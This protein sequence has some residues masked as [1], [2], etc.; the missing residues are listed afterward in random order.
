MWLGDDYGLSWD[1]T[2]NAEVGEDALRAYAGAP[3]YF[4][5]SNLEEHGPAYFMLFSATSRLIHAAAPGWPVADGRHLTNY[6]TFLA[7]VVIFYQ[8][9]LRLVSPRT[10]WVGAA[11]FATQPLLFGNAFVNQK[12]IPFMVFFMATVA[13]GI[14][15]VEEWNGSGL[16]QT[17]AHPQ[18]GASAW[19]DLVSGLRLEWRAKS[20]FARFLW[21]AALS[22]A[23]LLAL[24][25]LFVGTLARLG[26]A[27][28][29][30]AHEGRAPALIQQAFARV[31]SDA[32][33]T[34]VDAYLAKF[35]TLY[36]NLRVV[37]ASALTLGGLVALARAFPS[38]GQALGV[39]RPPLRRPGWLAS[40]VLLGLTI[41]IRQVGAFAGGMVSLYLLYRA[42]ARASFS[43]LAYWVIA[44][45]VTVASWP[46]LW[47]DPAGRLSGSLLHAA[48]FPFHYTL[49]RGGQIPSDALPPDYFPTLAGI[50][51]TEPAVL[52]VLTGCT[53]ASW[54]LFRRQQR[55]PLI[56]LLA[57][58]A[59]VPIFALMLRLFPAYGI[60][61]LLFVFP[62]LFVFAALGLDWVLKI[63]RRGWL[64]PVL[65]VIIVLPGVLAIAQLHPYEYA[66]FNTF[67]GGIGGAESEFAVDRQC[68]AYRE[69]A[70]AV[71]Q[72]ARPGSTVA[73][74]RLTDQVDPFLDDD[75]Q[76]VRGS[77]QA[78]SADF[79]ITCAGRPKGDWQPLG[80][81]RLYQVRR[82]SAVL[83]EVW[84]RTGQAD[85]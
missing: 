41:S 39:S 29:V 63:A 33:K 55:S 37:L 67:V 34:S 40:S 53:V 38:L 7:G 70:Q 80:F 61:H 76:M 10:A 62:P 19:H 2:R 12:D 4:W 13:L 6:L 73:V 50:Q 79:V 15:A 3:D 9:C 47:P 59:A 78:E 48:D 28:V 16:P 35:A 75:L 22:L 26:S 8:L 51:L 60:R 30:A 77:A 21:A 49:F 82:G 71:N 45:A 54:R 85:G 24:D 68:L 56:A 66:Y 17:G 43:V 11:L 64:L 57:V 69:A 74:L 18:P 27:I 32:Y 20:R 36:S 72:V 81:T 65:G 44:A 42:R 1:E 25:L 31:A 46:Y 83:A 52:L 23:L 14:S 5:H 58:W 84:R